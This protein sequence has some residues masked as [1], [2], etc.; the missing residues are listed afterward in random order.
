M[1][2]IFSYTYGHLFVFFG[3][4]FIHLKIKLCAFANKLLLPP[5]NVL[6]SWMEL[7]EGGGGKIT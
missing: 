3:K 4:M 5:C 6:P 7:K 1:I 2:S